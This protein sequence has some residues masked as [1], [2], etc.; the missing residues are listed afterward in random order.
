MNRKTTIQRWFLLFAAAFML[1]GTQATAQRLEITPDPLDLGERPINAWMRSVAYTLTNT[2]SDEIILNNAELDAPAFFGLDATSFPMTVAAG[3]SVKVFVNTNG[4]ALGGLLEGEFVAQ[5]GFNRNVTV[6]GLRATSYVPVQ[7]DVYENPFEITALPFTDAA[8]S[9]ASLKDNYLL[10][11]VAA[12]GFDAVYSFTLAT[13]QLVSVNLTGADAKMAIYAPFGLNEGPAAGNEIYAAEGTATDLQLFAGDYFL[14]VSTTAASYD[15]NVTAVTMPD[16]DAASIVAPLDGA[17]NITNIDML[18]WA[19]GNNTLEYQVVLGTTYPPANIVVDWADAVTTTYQLSNL[20]PNIQYFWQVNTRN[21]NNT[22]PTMGDIWGFTTTLTP[23]SA[24]TADAEIY[25]GED[26]V[27]TWESPVDRAFL[28]YNIFKDGVKLNTTAMLT[29]ATYTDLAPAYNMTGYDYTVTSIFDEGE[30]AMSTAFTVQVTGEGTLS[31]N[32]KDQITALNIAGA[33]VSIAGEDEF[34]VA[35]SYEA[36]TTATG[37]YTL[38]L[39]AGIYD[40][41][42]VKDGYITATMENVVVAYD[43]TTT[44]DFILLETAYPVAV[45]TASEFGENILIEWSFDATTFAPQ[46]MPFN[47]KGM[48]E[49]LVQKMWNKFMFDNN[50]DATA[51]GSDRALVEFE[52]WRMR[53]YLPGTMEMIGTTSQYQFVDFDWSVQDWGVYQ[54]YVKAVYSQSEA[55][56]VA[57]NSQDKDMLTVVD[58]IVALNSADSPGGTVVTFTNTS[59]PDLN[60]EYGIVLGLTGEHEWNAFRKGSYNIEVAKTGYAVITETADIYEAT[61]FEWLLEELLAVPADLYVTPTAFASWDAG[62]AAPFEPVMQDFNNGFGEWTVEQT[63]AVRT[64]IIEEDIYDNFDG[65]PYA[66]VRWDSNSQDELLVSPVMNTASASSLFVQFDQVYQD[67]S[68]TTD[69]ASV[70]VYDGANWVEVAVYEGEDYGSWY[71]TTDFE[72]LDVTAY[73]NANFQVRFRYVGTNDLYWAIDNVTVTDVPVAGRSFATYKIFLDEVLLGELTEE[74]YQLGTTFGET[75]TAGETYLV[76]VAAVY[77]TGQ[78]DKAAASFIYVPCEDYATPADFAATQLVGTLDIELS[79]TNLDA[80]AM[81]TVDGVVISRNGEEYALID[82]EDGVVASFID[83]DLEFGTYNYCITYVYD[84]GAETC[85]GVT[86]TEDVEITGGGYVNGTVTAFDGGAAIEGASIIVFNEDYSF[87]FTTDA[88]GF[89]TGEVVDGTYDYLVVADTYES[90]TLEGV[91]ITFGETVTND[92][93]LLEFPYAV[94]E[95]IATELSDAVVQLDWSG[96]GGGGGGGGDIAEWLYYDDGVNID[97]IGGPQTFTW[98]IKFDPDQLVDYDGASLTKIEIFNRTAA[99]D[100]LRIYEGTNA[101]TLLHTQTLSGLGVEVWEEV[102]LTDAVMLDVTKEL[103][104]AVY[105]TDGTNFP[106]AISTYSGS[107]NSDLITLDGAVWDNLSVLGL[108]GTWNLRGYVTDMATMRSAELPKAEATS[109]YNANETVAFARSGQLNTS[110]NAVHAS[111]QSSRELLGF[112]V[113]R[114]SCVTGELQFLGFTLDSLFTDNTWGAATSGVYKWGVV[115]EYSNNESEIVFSNCLDKDMNTTVSVTVTT[116]SGDSPE[117]TNVSFTNTSEPD[118]DLTYTT[119]LDATGYFAWDDFRKGTYDIYAEKLGF[120]A[121]EISDYVIDSPEAFVWML[122]ELLLPVSD[123]YVSPTGFATWSAGG[124]I[125][126]EPFI[127]D[128]SEGIDA[129]TRIPETNNWQM[130]QTNLAGGTEPEVR[131]YWSPNTTNRFYFISPM[132]STLS[133][134]EIEMSFDHIIDDFG[135]GYT[136]QL[137]T[138][139]DGVEYEVMSWP[140]ADAPAVN[141]VV[142]LTSAHGVGATDFQV[143][144]VFDGAAFDMNWWNIDNIMLYAPGTRELQ[145]YKVWLDGIYKADTPNTYYQYDVTDLVDGEEYFAE[146]AA[147]YS[148]GISEKMNYTWTYLSCDNYAGPEDLAAEVNGQDVTLTWGGTTPPPPPPGDGFSDDFEGHA[149]FAL[150]FAPWTNVDVDGSTTYGMSG[151]DWPNTYLAQAFILFNPSATTPALG[152]TPAHSGDKFAACFA[153]EVAPNND[154][155]IAPMTAIGAGYNVNFWAKSYTAD[156]GLERFKVGVSTTGT[157]PADFTIITP[158]SFVEAPANAWTE[159]SYDLSA[160]A[161]QEVYV[162]IQCVSNDA[163]FLMVDDFSIGTQ[164]ANFAFN[165][166]PATVGQANRATRAMNNSIYSGDFEFTAQSSKAVTGT[167]LGFQ[168]TRSREAVEIHYDGDYDNNAVGTGGAVSFMSAVRFTAAE[169]AAYYGEYELTDVKFVIHDNFFTN[170]TVKV[171]EGGSYG[172]PGTE[173]YS[174]DVTAMVTAATWTTVNLTEAVSLTEGNEYWIGYSVTT[175]G[176]YPAGVDAGPMVA[177]KGAWMYFNDAWDEL[178]TIAPTLNYNW[179]IR[180]IVNIAEGGGG[181]GGGELPEGVVGVNVYRDGMLIA[182][183]VQGNV[184]VDENVDFGAYTYCITYVY[185]DGGESC[186]T[187]C[188]DVDLNIVCDAP[189]ALTGEYLWTTDAWG[190][191]IEWN[192]PVNVVADWLFYD[193]GVNVDGIGGPASFTWAIKFDPAQ[194]AEYDG[195]SLTKIMLYNRTGATDELRIYEGNNAA[196]LLHTQPLG[197]LGIEVYEEV[198]LTTPVL[199]DVTKQLWIAVYSTDGVNFPAACG[200][201]TGSP[202]S[203]YITIDGTTWEHLSDVLAPYSWNLRGYVTT[204]AG[205]TAALPMDKPVDQ[206][207]NTGESFIVTGKPSAQAFFPDATSRAGRELELFNVYRSTSN[208]NYEL[209]AT[210]PFE[211]GVASFGYFDTDVAA[212]TD[213]YYQVTAFYNLEN[214]TCESE[215]AMA[216]ANPENDFV[217]VFVTNVNELGTATARLYPNPATE[218]VTIEAANMNRITVINAIGQVVYDREL[219]AERTQLNIA[220]YEAGIYMVRI[221]TENGLVT[222][223]MSIVR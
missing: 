195:A 111:S 81:D 206:I 3:E 193:D 5:W 66:Y 213:Y 78:S 198:T 46:V 114:T 175:T 16:A 221:N 118:L 214:A 203:D 84:S 211:E 101:A 157:N 68:G 13:D 54:W 113:Y 173:V 201:Y 162:G 166:A 37:N 134:T 4:S 44:E 186:L 197:G 26:V 179:N 33:V 218:N 41:T 145:G 171:W 9:T 185:E 100:E 155:L 31:G 161:G 216:Q 65:T 119:Q 2:S 196:T 53:E 15:L 132:M 141:E 20:Q 222:K 21:N 184:Y 58:L 124:V 167:E 123:L 29:A 136:I 74:E 108:D 36:T 189:K 98:A 220:T 102:E 106:A 30:S 176:G 57:S 177:G 40:L 77:T 137:V 64:W 27:L 133:Q 159:F 99:A 182:D 109:N 128:F 43:A 63:N 117:G 82:F 93:V 70:E 169:L 107:P 212:Q 207:S 138:I 35:Q 121:I 69:R 172:T 34:G 156:Y 88:S 51:Q 165:D 19:F 8:V 94:D 50:F 39:L 223:R 208:S 24:L 191:M 142:T 85:Q 86:C 73:K 146:V 18:E 153:S 10:T 7:G 83:E 170:V 187:E 104:I 52:I 174:Q 72:S 152:D 97:G 192:S 96:N 144:F 129:W 90:Q 160:Y 217:A 202:N 92:F 48:S 215:P 148:N 122:E 219:S 80:A 89:Y 140:A 188:V 55:A 209:I 163:F 56:L 42:V 112:N 126:F 79:W 139:A 47:T 190:A 181:G 60:L 75:L 1:L 131:F 147:V 115:A 23:P 32:V 130:S 110:A 87:E 143:A 199:L 127:E 67:Y 17:T 154:W 14:V 150:D 95:V 12:D 125:P 61:S 204:V 91:V 194:L 38:D 180:G 28:G 210:V 149:D 103:W 135:G 164:A 158:G 205:A 11:G 116:N 71:T 105:T 151:I 25:E 76:E 62:V 59:E 45:V 178:T 200:N 22:T 49:E 183:A 120:G 6:A 168:S